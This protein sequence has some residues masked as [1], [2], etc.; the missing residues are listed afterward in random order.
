MD[1]PLEEYLEKVRAYPRKTY[2]VLA[3]VVSYIILILLLCG[4]AWIMRGDW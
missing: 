2:G 4:S 3:A 1:D